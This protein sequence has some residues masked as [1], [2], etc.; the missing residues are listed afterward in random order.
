MGL[1]LFDLDN[2]L[3][4]GDSDYLWGVFLA[5]KGIV[6]G[7]QYERENQ[8]FYDE[9]KSGTLDIYEFLRFSLKP[10]ADNDAETL[11][12]LQAEFVEEKIQPIMSPASFTLIEKHKNCR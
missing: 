3:L 1:A 2:T 5:E 11:K 8:R 6:D 9:Y 4:A 10:L 7:E 12:K